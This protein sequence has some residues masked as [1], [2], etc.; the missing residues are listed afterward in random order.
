MTFGLDFVEHNHF[1]AMPEVSDY[2]EECDAFQQRV[3]NEENLYS[4]HSQSSSNEISH[5]N[6]VPVI[7]S[8]HYL[9]NICNKILKGKFA[10]KTHISTHS[11]E[12]PFVC[13]IC[14]KTFAKKQILQEHAIIHTGERPFTCELCQK[15][16][17]KKCT[18]I[19]HKVVH[20]GDKKH[21]CD[22]CNKKFAQRSGV[23]KHRITHTGERPYSCNFC[24][25]VF[26]AKCSLKKHC[27][28]FHST[29]SDVQSE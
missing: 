16:F 19:K 3:T 7:L 22:I 23:L 13:N 26:S 8:P 10:L 24:D 1:E 15:S 21:S 4:A 28:K 2:Q 17:A 29:E 14:N 9:C 25:K 6:E 11:G 27:E 18:L 12:R 20:T 5:N